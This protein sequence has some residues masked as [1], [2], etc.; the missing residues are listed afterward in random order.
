[1]A[2]VLVIDDDTVILS[3]VSGILEAHGHTVALAKDGRA[4]ETIFGASHVDLIITDIVMAGQEGMA[5]IGAI[6][7]ASPK[8]PIL[9]MSGSNTVGRYGSYL[10]AAKLLGANATLSKPITVDGLM[11]LVDRLLAPEGAHPH[12]E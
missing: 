2:H 10:D 8:V 9:A 11:Q 12:F 5:T 1:M 3:L 7:R 4:G 6:R